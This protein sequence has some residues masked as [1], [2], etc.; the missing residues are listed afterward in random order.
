MSNSNDS[1]S[2][3]AGDSG[4]HP[5]PRIR[6]S[7]KQRAWLLAKGSRIEAYT[8]CGMRF[9]CHIRFARVFC[10]TPDGGRIQRFS[11]NQQRGNRC[12]S[13]RGQNSA[14]SYATSKGRDAGEVGVDSYRRGRTT[15]RCRD[16]LPAQTQGE[17]RWRRERRGSG[18][19]A[20][21][22]EKARDLSVVFMEL[23]V[24]SGRIC[25]RFL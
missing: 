8:Y 11:G 7:K 25:D 19:M 23:E 15:G 21:A 22:M 20:A 12:G 16:E 13:L 24:T 2:K 1:W 10:A 9:V 4:K 14:E 6:R 18:R 17:G 3:R 5:T